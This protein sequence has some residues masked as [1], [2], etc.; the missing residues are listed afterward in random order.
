M[1]ELA[2]VMTPIGQCQH[3]NGPVVIN[4]VALECVGCGYVTHFQHGQSGA[5]WPDTPLGRYARRFTL[6]AWGMEPVG[7]CLVNDRVRLQH[8]REFA[9]AGGA[10]AVGIEHE[11]LPIRGE[12]R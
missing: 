5:E 6:G 2:H 1:T 8:G 9:R 12:S 11:E 10:T 3:T 7:L 4:L